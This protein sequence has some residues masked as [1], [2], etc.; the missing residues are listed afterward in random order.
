MP[1]QHNRPGG[2]CR[3]RGGPELGPSAKGSQPSVRQL[4][5]G[6]NPKITPFMTGFMNPADDSFSGRPAYF[7]QL[8]DG[9][10]L[11]SDEQL[12]AVYRISYVR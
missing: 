8:P 5:V 9:S 12:G 3:A 10:L 11:I 7:L 1:G 6:R 4:F 2:R